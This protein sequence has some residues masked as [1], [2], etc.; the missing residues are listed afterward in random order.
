MLCSRLTKQSSP[1][2]VGPTG[3]W[4]LSHS[5]LLFPLPFMDERGTVAASS[6][7]DVAAASLSYACDGASSILRTHVSFSGWWG[8]GL[9]KICARSPLFEDWG[10][11]LRNWEKNIGKGDLVE[12]I[13][14]PLSPIC[15]FLG[16][17][18]CFSQF[19]GDALVNQ[20][21]FVLYYLMMWQ[22][23]KL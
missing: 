16:K 6:P 17:G 14:S 19:A 12:Q 5:S 9:R 7:F 20:T 4:H 23:I 2:H 1:F 22:T 10:D 11:V 15:Q 8:K 3:Q 13:F 18:D 21:L